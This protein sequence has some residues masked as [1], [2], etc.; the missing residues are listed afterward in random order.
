M[1]R[2]VAA[3]PLRIRPQSER[4]CCSS[5]HLFP[6]FPWEKIR[7]AGSGLPGP[8]APS[9]CSLGAQDRGLHIA[10][11]PAT[12]PHLAPPTLLLWTDD[13]TR[14]PGSSLRE[15]WIQTWHPEHTFGVSQ[16]GQGWGG[17]LILPFFSAVLQQNPALGTLPR[18]EGKGKTI[19]LHS[20]VFCLQQLPAKPPAVTAAGDLRV[21][22]PCSG[23]RRARGGYTDQPWAV[24]RHVSA[25]VYSY[26]H[27]SEPQRS[28]LS[29]GLLMLAHKG[30]K[31]N[32]KGPPSWSSG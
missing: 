11:H 18:V 32:D 29:P 28:H 10:T 23:R 31:D 30:L 24:A 14:A 22:Q 3:Q 19:D 7:A 20:Q 4:D 15:V 2:Q 5:P 25:W 6:L 21:C 8:R 27:L 26:H 13:R 17:N 12:P 16:W 9:L 1:S